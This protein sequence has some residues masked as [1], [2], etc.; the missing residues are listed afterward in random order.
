MKHGN[1]QTWLKAILFFG[2]LMVT[3]PMQAG[4]KTKT[5]K[6]KEKGK[7][8]IEVTLNDSTVIKGRLQYF[9]T[10]LMTNWNYEFSMYNEN[11]EIVEL[12]ADDVREVYFPDNKDT[13]YAYY[14]PVQSTLSLKK[15]GKRLMGVV[16][17]TEH[18]TVYFQY[19]EHKSYKE[20]MNHMGGF[21][22]SYRLEAMHLQM[23]GD[24]IAYYFMSMS[25]PEP[26]YFGKFINKH[27]PED[28][29]YSQ[30]AQW[31]KVWCKKYKNRRTVAR[32]PGY[33]ANLYEQFLQEKATP[34]ESE[35]Q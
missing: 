29:I 26:V 19:T 3:M 35:L 32:N 4:N 18:A 31:L 2:V 25:G 5:K 6:P 12:T 28:S 1:Q 34:T 17:K 21:W 22:H 11:G 23:E 9:W 10:R 14:Y 27:H 20:N 13:Q 7:E 24:S 33:M 30:F 8:R 16:N 15:D